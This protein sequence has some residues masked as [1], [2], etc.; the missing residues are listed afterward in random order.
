MPPKDSG[1]KSEDDD[2]PYRPVL[3]RQGDFTHRNNDPPGTFKLHEY[4]VDMTREAI[5][6]DFDPMRK[7]FSLR[8]VPPPA[9]V[10][11][12][13]TAMGNG[14]NGVWVGTV[15][16]P[17]AEVPGATPQNLFAPRFINHAYPSFVITRLMLRRRYVH[18]VGPFKTTMV[19]AD[20][21]CV[22]NP[23]SGPQ[24]G[25]SFIY[26]SRPTDHHSGQVEQKGPDGQV[27]SP[28][29]QRAELRAVVMALEF[30]FWAAEGWEQVVMTTMSDYVVTGATDRLRTWPG[31]K[32]KTARGT[33]VANRD[34]WERLSELLG[35]YAAGGCEVKFWRME[36][37]PNWS[38]NV[39][40][41][42]LNA[43][44][45]DSARSMHAL[46]NSKTMTSSLALTLALAMAPVTVSAAT[47]AGAVNM[48]NACFWQ[49]GHG[50]SAWYEGT[51]AYD[52]YC[53]G[54]RSCGKHSIN[55]TAYCRIRYGP[56]AYADPQGGGLFDW[57][58]F[59]P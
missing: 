59:F 39:R 17:E 2:Y 4:L 9:A 5:N 45:K 7:V 15:F 18:R 14:A 25:W 52:W 55:V 48:E 42:A 30:R 37:E 38:Y 27:H 3:N 12:A 54:C 32:W 53:S 6:G 44:E 50:Y 13:Q 10:E 57:G 40:Q 20:G 31:R 35:Q 46:N 19:Y 49:Y 26:N 22:D 34:L 29:A 36:R 51:T 23:I 41:A 1:Y 21:V 24:A 58:C 43:A 8:P 11:R 16:N 47:Y 33:D 28:T 56:T